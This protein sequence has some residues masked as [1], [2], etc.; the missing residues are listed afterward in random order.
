[1]NKGINDVEAAKVMGLAAQTL[2]NWRHMRKGPKYLKMGRAVR[3]DL[4]DIVEFM[5]N[6]TINPERLNEEEKNNV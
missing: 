3:Y 5:K 2:R 4:V 6:N 1:M